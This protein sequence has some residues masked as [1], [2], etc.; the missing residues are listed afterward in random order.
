MA[1]TKL[2]RLKESIRGNKAA[3][4]KNNLEY[5][6]NPDKCGGGVWIGG[7][8]GMTPEIIF[9][10][11]ADNKK[12]WGKEDGSQG[13]HYVI[14]FPPEENVN[15]ALAY[16][17]GEDF[18]RE[19]LGD[20]Y[21]YAFAVHNDQHHMH[22]HITFDSVSKTDGCKFHSPNGDWEKRIQPITDRICKKY[23]LDELSFTEE[24]KGKT[25]G[26]WKSD[27][28][29]KKTGKR[30]DVTWY[31]LIRDDIDEAI[32]RCATFEEA[33]SCLKEKG[34]TVRL[35]KYLSVKPWGKERPVRTSRLGKGYSLD[36][37]RERILSKEVLHDEKN[38]VRYGDSEEII[39]VLKLKRTGTSWKM[40]PFQK[41]YYE[42]WRNSFL[43]NKPGREKPYLSNRD[44]VRIRQLSNAVKFMIDQDIGDFETLEKRWEELQGKK[45]A[46]RTEKETLQTKLYRRSPLMHLK[47]YEKLKRK[48]KEELSPEEVKEMASLF[49]K[50]ENVM[51]IDK[52][53]ELAGAVKEQIERISE[54]EK[55][56]S[57]LEKP[58]DDVYT[59][60]F[61]MP[62]PAKE[63]QKE[64]K[65]KEKKEMP[66]GKQSTRQGERT[67]ITVNQKLILSDDGED[68]YL[69]KIPGRDEAV[70][71]PK[72]DCFLYKSG[73]VL[74][75]YLYDDESYLTFSTDGTPMKEEKGAA[76]KTHFDKQKTRY[77][78]K[79][80]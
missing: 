15:E 34:Y 38:Y 35:S 16:Q 2:L 21:Y 8:A 54:K 69:I 78:R 52:A 65:K 73:T 37:I 12:F 75:A 30:K 27:R 40:T 14:S 13:F 74:S 18:T 3:H 41:R 79:G 71:L 4:L 29:E 25:Y 49:L 23:G 45:E 67:R 76:L 55:E 43:R 5:I 1:I 22:V 60:Y 70:R 56:L 28:E 53:R 32:S 11:M 62:S 58:L 47:R 51:S 72:K 20:D 7:N 42:R 68:G 80:R 17:I 36:E 26:Q 48:R 9:Q 66:S 33:L 57:A 19:L 59:F 6:C 50:I 63:H 64:E 24:R 44:V 77:V 61:D 31:D 39:A 46:L 10:T